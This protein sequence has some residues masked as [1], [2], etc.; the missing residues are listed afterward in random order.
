[1]TDDELM[2]RVAGGDESA[3]RALV[4]RWERPIFTFLVRM[5]RSQDEAM[6]LAQETFLRMVRQ[7]GRYRPSGQFR[8]WLFR[9]AGNL[10][11]SRLRRRK[12]VRW[13]PFDPEIHDRP[14]PTGGADESLEREET[15]SAV[16]AA[17]DRLPDRQRQAVILRQYEELSYEEIAAAMGATVPAV[18]SL[19]HRAMTALRKELGEKRG[20]R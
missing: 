7:A 13:L 2:A 14:A 11:R 20:D 16:R 3:C 1:M 10:A 9:I 12:L 15:R 18:E 17:L 4:E 5:V 19:L 6:E 8:G